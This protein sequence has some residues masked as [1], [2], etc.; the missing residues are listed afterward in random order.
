MG[1]GPVAAGR[2]TGRGPRSGPSRPR[3]GRRPRSGATGRSPPSLGPM[4]SILA[5]CGRRTSS[6]STCL[7]GSTPTGPSASGGGSRAPSGPGPPSGWTSTTRPC[8]P[9]RCPDW[10]R[11]RPPPGRARWSTCATGAPSRSTPAATPPTSGRWT[12]PRWPGAFGTTGACTGGQARPGPGTAIPPPWPRCASTPPATAR[13]R[14]RWTA[15]PRP[16]SRPRPRSW[17][18]SAPPWPTGAGALMPLRGG[19]PPT[20]TGRT[21]TWPGAS[22]SCCRRSASRP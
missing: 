3:T 11:P 16:G 4:S 7:G 1:R 19:S 14:W 17:S 20:S 12:P 18:C 6:G 2:R 9:S 21:W 10:P 5:R 13:P 15:S 8:S 22:A